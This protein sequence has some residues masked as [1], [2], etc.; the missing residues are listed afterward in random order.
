MATY[1]YLSQ[2]PGPE[3]RGEFYITNDHALFDRLHDDKEQIEAAYGN[4][5][6]W[7]AQPANKTRKI[8][9]FWKVDV[10]DED[11]WPEY[12]DWLIDRIVRLRDVM[13]ERL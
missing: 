5:L 11:R 13:K 4:P 6:G 3:L 12:Y 2:Q 8:F 10:A 9:D 7:H 1:G